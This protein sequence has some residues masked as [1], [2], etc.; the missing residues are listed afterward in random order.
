MRVR[1]CWM[2]NDTE[3]SALG[4]SGCGGRVHGVALA[5]GGLG[6][7]RPGALEQQGDAARPHVGLQ[8]RNVAAV[9]EIRVGRYWRL[10]LSLPGAAA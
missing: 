9:A 2:K 7:L 10:A 3:H 5:L 6:R 4:N 8:A 1:T